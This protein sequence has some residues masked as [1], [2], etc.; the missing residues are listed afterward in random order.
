MLWDPGWV[1]LPRSHIWTMP[2]AAGRND[3]NVQGMEVAAMLHL[4]LELLIS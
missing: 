4:G 1:V 3:L 2:S